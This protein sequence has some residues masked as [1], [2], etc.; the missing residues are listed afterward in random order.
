MSDPGTQSSRPKGAETDRSE[1]VLGRVGANSAV[2]LASYGL[3]TVLA[4][5]VAVF[6]VRYL[7][8]A[9]YGLLTTAYA[10]ISFFVIFTSIGVDTLI[11]RDVARHPER[12]EEIVSEAIGLRLLLSVV[13]MVAAWALLPVLHPTPRL[14]FL[15]VLLTLTFPFSFS[16]LYHV[17]YI[18]ELRQAVPKLVIGI[19]SV[20]LSLAKLALIPLGAPIEAFVGLEVVS[21]V[22]VF[23]ASVWLGLRSGLRPRVRWTPGRWRTLLAAS[24][25]VALAGTFIQVYLRIDQL[26][27]FR[28]TGITEVGLYAV[29]VR[30]VEF[31]NVLPIVFM[32]SVFP[33]LSRLWVESQER[34]RRVVRLSFRA[35]AWASFPMAAYLFIFADVLLPAVF[36]A[37][38]V[39]SVPAMRWLAWSIPPTFLNSVL[40]NQLFASGDQRLAAGLAGAAAALNVA[41]NLILIGPLGGEG[42]AMATLGAY[43]LVVPLSLA[44]ARSR[45]AALMGLGSVVRPGLGVA[46]ALAVV[47]LTNPGFIV[48][49]LLFPAVYVVLLVLTGEV[50][51]EE[52]TLMGRAM[53]RSR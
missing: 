8:S 42:A 9:E 11:Q 24:W 25:P 34:Q 17:L 30:V 44:S 4:G 2:L 18:V 27:L 33:L 43:A 39:G 46:G 6:L 29:S 35:M 50:G 13:S 19:W 36:G 45:Q 48:G 38:F 15:T 26:M 23:S 52:L 53:G 20:V 16:A 49:S 22:V 3:N 41:L 10:Y 14:A 1:D 12:A 7:G 47:V 5:V 37:E 32:G 40:Y 28:M 31:A 51:R 21:A